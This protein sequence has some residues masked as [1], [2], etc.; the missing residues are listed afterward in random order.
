VRN[1]KNYIN[2]IKKN[3]PFFHQSDSENIFFHFIVAL[4]QQKW[5]K[6]IFRLELIEMK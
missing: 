4:W 6:D 1:K 3:L 2:E 5:K